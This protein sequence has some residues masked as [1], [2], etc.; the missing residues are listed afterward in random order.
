[1]LIALSV[2]TSRADVLY[3]ITGFQAPHLISVDPLTGAE[4]TSSPFA[5]GVA[6]RGLCADGADLF[7]IEGL[8]D[9]ISDRL[10]RITPLTGVGS[11][12]GNTLFNWSV[13]SC[14]VHRPT[15]TLYAI[16]DTPGPTPLLFRISKSTGAA[17]LVATSAFVPGLDQVTALAI[18]PAGVA[19]VSDIISTSLFRLDLGTGTLTFIGDSGP[20]GTNGGF[21]D[22]GF[23]SSGQ[24]WGVR[25]GGGLYRIDTNTAVATRFANSTSWSGLAFRWEAVVATEGTT[26]ARL[27]AHYR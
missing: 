6:L 18:S 14:D 22:L 2:G 4:L 25:A 3:A 26:W 20:I 9:N 11:A 1:M 10:Y 21:N 7:S 13:R 23:D 12:V 5:A 19:Y 15:N 16:T 8:D 17:T 24:L 27:K